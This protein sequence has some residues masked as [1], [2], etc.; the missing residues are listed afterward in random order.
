MQGLSSH[1][2]RLRRETDVPLGD[3]SLLLGV[4]QHDY[5]SV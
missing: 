5:L 2:M 4:F 1:S 3:V